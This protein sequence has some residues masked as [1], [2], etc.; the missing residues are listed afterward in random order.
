QQEWVLTQQREHA[1]G[2]AKSAL[3]L[4]EEKSEE[5]GDWLSAPE[6][7]DISVMLDQIQDP[8]RL[9][10]ALVS[11]FYQFAG[12]QLYQ[13]LVSSHQQ[14]ASAQQQLEAQAKAEE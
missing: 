4:M 5:F 2:E 8:A 9:K 13:E 11:A 14:A 7:K 3:P 10:N 6:N 12:P 1:I